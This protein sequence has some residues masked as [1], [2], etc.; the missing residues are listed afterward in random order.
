[1]LAETELLNRS[2]FVVNIVFPGYL[3]NVSQLLEIMTDS[4]TMLALCNVNY[5]RWKS[6]DMPL[7]ERQ[8]ELIYNRE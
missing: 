7:N 6:N 8:K 2:V 5:L 4:D 1:M 3:E